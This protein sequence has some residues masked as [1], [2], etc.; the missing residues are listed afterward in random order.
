[1]FVITSKLVSEQDEIYG[2]N[3]INWEDSA[4]KLF[5]FDWWRRSRRK[6]NENPQT[7][8]AWEDRLTWFKSSPEN[9]GL[10]KIDGEPME[11]EWNIFPGSNTVAA[12]PQSPRVPVKIERKARIIYRTDHLHVDVQRHLMGIKGQRERMR[13]KCSNRFSHCK[14]IFRRTMVIPRTWI[15][16]EK[17]LYSRIQSRRRMGQSCGAD[18][19]DTCRKQTPSLPIHESIFHRSA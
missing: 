8:M 13:I 16:K 9:R 1:M 11:F 19:V 6:V 5:F 17:V 4:W 10:D 3:T 18:D 15:R 7:N 14:K 2:V 12:Q